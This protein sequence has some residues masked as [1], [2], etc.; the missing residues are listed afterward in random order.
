[1]AKGCCRSAQI[2]GATVGGAGQAPNVTDNSVLLVT[3]GNPNVGKTTL[4]NALSGSNLRIG[5][6]PGTTV[7]R[8]E[9]N[10][11]YEGQAV[12]L[13]DLP[14]SYSLAASTAEERLT[15]DELLAQHPRAVIDVVDAGNVERN[16]AL[17]IELIELGL[18]VIVAL[19][20]VDEAKSKGLDIDFSALSKA[21]DLPVIATVAVREDGTDKLIASALSSRPST[22]KVHYHPLIESAVERISSEIDDPG[23]RW[24]ALS[25]LMD[26]KVGELSAACK[27]II[28]RERRIIAEHGLDPFLEIVEARY[29]TARELAGKG[30]SALPGVHKLTAAIDGWFLH[31]WLGIPCFMLGMLLLFR[32]TFVLSAPWLDWLDTVKGVLTGWVVGMPLPKL[33]SAFLVGGVIEGLGTVLALTPVLFVLYFGL[34][35]MEASGFLS[36]SSF[37]VDRIMKAMG[38]PGKAFIPMLVGFGCNVPG[39]TA[40]KTLESFSERLRVAVSVPFVPCSARM[41]VFT[42]FAALFFP[43]KAFLVMFAVCALGV[44]LGLL[45]TLVMGKIV[46]SDDPGS[47]MELPPYRIP[48]LKVLWKQASA[49]TVSFLQGAGTA[50][51]VAVVL[52]WIFLNIP[53]GAPEESIFGQLSNWFVWVMSPLGITDWRLAG[54]LIPGFVAKEVVVGTLA[55]SFLG[56]ETAVPIGFLPGLETI[57]VSFLEAIWG[58]ICAIPALIGLPQLGPESADAP[59]GLAANITRLMTPA[60]SLAYIVFICLYTPCVATLAALRVEFGTK[61]A[62]ISAFGHLVIAWL[63]AFVVYHGALLVLG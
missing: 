17:T 45:V 58:T 12:R 50:I 43:R 13:V 16:L 14:G 36:R 7:E 22:F 53:G 8:M 46:D 60:S 39:I 15:R 35:F 59:V 3:V 63:V 51:L 37:L 54:A 56:V 55:I 61:W 10:F 30:Q 52:V 28:K 48:T 33:L 11:T 18:P 44:C 21:M 27:R 34:S 31:R 5:N 1:M 40:T 4:V 23:A 32:F 42:F 19:N 25:A 49:R 47:I 6:W 57:A 9:T 26:E 38:L 2:T 41:A 62:L 20:L 24:L 29:R